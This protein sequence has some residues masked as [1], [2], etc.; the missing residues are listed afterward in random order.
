MII[1]LIIIHDLK[2]KRIGMCA[3]TGI[4]FFQK[5]NYKGTCQA[6]CIQQQQLA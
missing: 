2:S 3:Y 5:V 6:A 4:V 1:K